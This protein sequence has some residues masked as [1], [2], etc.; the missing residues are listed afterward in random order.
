VL[1]DGRVVV[2]VNLYASTPDAFDGRH[3][4]LAEVC[5]ALASGAVT[6]ADL[7]FTTRFRAAEAPDRLRDQ[8]T[9]DRAAGVLMSERSISADE[10][11]HQIRRA[12]HRAGITDTDMARAIL[13]LFVDAT[14]ETLADDLE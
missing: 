4:E 7:A 1:Q 10:A 11:V 9:V 14:D 6:N 13:G 12:A 8:N 2:G 3:D 5:G